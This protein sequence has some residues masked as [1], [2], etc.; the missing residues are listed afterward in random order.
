M[1]PSREIAAALFCYSIAG[2]SYGSKN[3]IEIIDD[4]G[5]VNKI[6]AIAV[7]PFGSTDRRWS[8]SGDEVNQQVQVEE[9]GRAVIVVVSSCEEIRAVV[10]GKVG[11]GTFDVGQI[12]TFR[13]QEVGWSFGDAIKVP[14]K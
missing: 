8:V 5:D 11:G 7:G 3:E 12:K 4:I 10:S 6:V 1:G 2:K 14:F 13:S 9:I